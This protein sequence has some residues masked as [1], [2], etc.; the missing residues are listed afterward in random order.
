MDLDLSMLTDK[1]AIIMP[2]LSYLM[3]FLTNMFDT[4]RAYLEI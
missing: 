3:Q 2:Y 1:F 4:F